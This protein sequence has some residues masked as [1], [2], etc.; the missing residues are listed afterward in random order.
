MILGLIA[1]RLPAASAS[2][3]QESSD[4]GGVRM[5]QHG[6]TPEAQ[7]GVLPEGIGLPPGHLAPAAVLQDVMGKEVEIGR[8][9]QE[10]PVL[11]VFYRGGW[12]PYC[13]FQIHEMSEALPEFQRR[14]VGLVAV[15]VDRFEEAARTQTLHE[16]PFPVLSDPDLILHQAFH[17]IHQADEAEV[18][19]LAQFGIDL[20]ASSGRGH[21][22]I[23][24]PSIFLIA[25]GGRILWAHADADYQTRPTI[26]QLLAVTEAR[27]D[28]SMPRE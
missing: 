3:A 10:G 15:S 8:F 14:G 11:L 27:F 7:L 19:M 25:K 21:N 12:C 22:A 4:P 28:F 5:K 26:A 1:G 24:V 17:V 18:A 13:N 6:I 16:I 2:S 9:W 23:A 20:E